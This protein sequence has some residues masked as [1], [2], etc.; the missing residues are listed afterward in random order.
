MPGVSR[1]VVQYQP[2]WR[3]PP[4]LT[5][6]LTAGLARDAAKDVTD[7]RTQDRQDGNNDD[8]HQDEDQ[9]VLDQPLTFFAWQV[10]SASL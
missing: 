8:G 7:L 4:A 9:R 6:A 1:L 3:H 10:Q 2:T 5:V